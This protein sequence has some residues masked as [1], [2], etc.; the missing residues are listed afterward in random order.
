MIKKIIDIVSGTYAHWNQT[1]NEAVNIIY[2]GI[3]KIDSDG[4]DL[5]KKFLACSNIISEK[6]LSPDRIQPEKIKRS[7]IKKIPLSD[8][9]ILH[10]RLINIFAS[11]HLQ[12]NPTYPVPIQKGY[13]LLFNEEIL[14]PSHST[15]KNDEAIKE[16][17]YDGLKAAFA[18]LPSLNKV[19]PS[20]DYIL[21]TDVITTYRAIQL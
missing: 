9:L 21:F 20:R 12:L 2:K 13:V 4:T 14:L 15:L 5:F 11:L 18:H 17:I 3:D 8:F 6:L 1:N 10:K 19:D 16:I 7:E